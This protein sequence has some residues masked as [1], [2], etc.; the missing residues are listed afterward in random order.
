[1]VI[2]RVVKPQRLPTLGTCGNDHS[3]SKSDPSESAFERV[4]QG[5]L[6]WEILGGRSLPGSRLL[7]C[8]R[9]PPGQAGSRMGLINQRDGVPHF[10]LPM[11]GAA[12]LGRRRVLLGN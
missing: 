9:F 8:D 10:M 7:W 3:Q 6:R 2:G 1:M 4:P 12:E 5:L 11:W